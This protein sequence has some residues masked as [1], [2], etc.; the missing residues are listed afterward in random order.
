MNLRVLMSSTSMLMATRLLSRQDKAT[1]IPVPA[2]F[3]GYCFNMF[4]LSTCNKS[5]VK[6]HLSEEVRGYRGLEGPGN[7]SEQATLYTKFIHDFM[8][9]LKYKHIL[10]FFHNVSVLFPFWSNKETHYMKM[11]YFY[12]L[13]LF[14]ILL[15][16]MRTSVLKTGP[17]V[18][19]N[20]LEA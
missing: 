1:L 11:G 4:L 9:F 2:F 19:Q 15:S 8:L 13:T 12:C 17:E 20:L 6:A 18:L 5:R 7:V 14:I 3:P 16:L 10:H